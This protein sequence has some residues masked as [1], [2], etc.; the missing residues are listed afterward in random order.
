MFSSRNEQHLESLISS[1]A[2]PNYTTYI[3]RVGGTQVMHEREP[4][5]WNYSSCT[6]G[7][8]SIS[9]PS[10]PNKS[11]SELTTGTRTNTTCVQHVLSL[12]FHLPVFAKDTL[13]TTRC[14]LRTKLRLLLIQ[15]IM[16]PAPWRMFPNSSSKR[17]PRML[18]TRTTIIRIIPSFTCVGVPTVGV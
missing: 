17:Q 9:L 8:T 3:N 14:L 15:R 6:T 2:S 10:I 16:T 18:V 7:R 12:W 4:R 1:E 11:T 5:C 13:A